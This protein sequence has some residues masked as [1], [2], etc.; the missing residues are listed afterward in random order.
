[1]PMTTKANNRVSKVVLDS[2]KYLSRIT[3]NNETPT[4]LLI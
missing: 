2:T 3:V 4:A 1:M